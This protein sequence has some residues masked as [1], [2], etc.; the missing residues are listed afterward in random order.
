MDIFLPQMTEHGFQKK[1]F[2]KFIFNKFGG[3]VFFL[4]NIVNLCFQPLLAYSS[5]NFKYL[6]RVY[7]LIPQSG[8]AM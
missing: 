4:S 3:E 8:L 6:F 2:F 1:L 7:N 5:R